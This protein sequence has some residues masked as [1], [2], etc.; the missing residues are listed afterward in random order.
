MWGAHT[1]N[2]A[3]S[4]NSN[5]SSRDCKP[6]ALTATYPAIP[7][8]VSWNNNWTISFISWY[9]NTSGVLEEWFPGSHMIV[10]R[11]SDSFKYKVA[12]T[13]ACLHYRNGL[14]KLLSPPP[15]IRTC[16]PHNLR[17]TSWLWAGLSGKKHSINS[18]HINH[19][20]SDLCYCCWWLYCSYCH[21]CFRWMNSHL[22]M[23]LSH[24]AHLS[25]M[26]RLDFGWF[27]KSTLVSLTYPTT[28]E[29][30]CALSIE[31]LLLTH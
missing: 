5:P 24:P 12:L 23:T 1:H 8:F 21:C 16:A 2:G 28:N 10:P 14:L 30:V 11:N 15:P 31:K 22:R 29:I 25:T 19:M 27:S 7:I 9:N 4:L 18:S 26:K 17:R 20:T 13:C 3:R 6:S